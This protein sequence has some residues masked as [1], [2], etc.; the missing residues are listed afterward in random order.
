M[1]DVRTERLALSLF[2]W[3]SRTFTESS[4]AARDRRR[5]RS[6]TLLDQVVA[7]SEALGIS[8]PVRRSPERRRRCS[9]S[10]E[11]A[12]GHR[13]ALDWARRHLDDDL[14]KVHDGEPRRDVVKP[15][16]KHWLRTPPAWL[17]QQAGGRG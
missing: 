15:M 1:A 8:P 3:T 14:E 2:T 6:A 10:I 11:T 16:T 4:N 7:W 9:G 13:P 17:S 12:P 5:R